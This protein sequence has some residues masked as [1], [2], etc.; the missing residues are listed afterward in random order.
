MAWQ[1]LEGEG[2]PLLAV[3]QP[4]RA[5]GWAGAAAWVKESSSIFSEF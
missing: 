5:A 4:L 3:T 1:C 2:A